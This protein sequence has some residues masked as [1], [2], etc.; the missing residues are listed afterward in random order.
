MEKD[1]TPRILGSVLLEGAQNVGFQGNQKNTIVLG[2]GD[3]LRP[4]GGP[5]LQ[6]VFQE[7]KGYP[8]FQGAPI[9]R[10]KTTGGLAFLLATL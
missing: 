1:S 5:V 7:K 6:W 8:P 9:L 2:F 10:R 4:N 3:G